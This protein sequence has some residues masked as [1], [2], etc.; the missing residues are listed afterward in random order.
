MEDVHHLGSHVGVQVTGRLVGKNNLRIT[1]DGTGYG[2]TLALSA[3]ELPRMMLHAV[4]QP[5]ACEYLFSQPASFLRGD[6]AIE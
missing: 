4:A 1:D 2:D 6:V 3:G 5:D